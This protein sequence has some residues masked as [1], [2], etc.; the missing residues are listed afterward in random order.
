MNLSNDSAKYGV[1][2]YRFAHNYDLKD[3]RFTIAADGKKYG[4]TF[5]GKQELTFDAG[6][7]PLTI[8]YEC[9]KIDKQVY[10]VRFGMRVA[11]LDTEN[12]LATL[13]LPEGYVFGV[14]E[15][16][17]AAPDKRHTFSEEMVGTAVR[18]VFGV[19]RFTDRIYFEEA[20][21]R[22]SF[23]P[24]EEAFAFY[25]TKAVKI[26]EGMFLV[27]VEGQVPEFIC[28]PPGSDRI[29][30]LEDYEHMLFAGCITGK[31]GTIMVGG[32]G[33]FHDYDEALFK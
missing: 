3:K 14:I 6:D 27:D 26:K 1:G 30:V 5:N 4:L 31:A 13:V 20:R 23:S 17:Q 12:G 11:A 22:A 28:V 2:Q 18:W 8:G 9:L 29:L 7:K 16:S 24:K 15:G 32:Y 10:F 19:G 33:D 21:C 25:R